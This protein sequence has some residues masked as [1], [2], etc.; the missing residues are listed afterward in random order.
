MQGDSI[1]EPH[2][3]LWNPSGNC[4]AVIHQ[5]AGRVSAVNRPP[6]TGHSPTLK[7]ASSLGVLLLFFWS[8][9]MGATVTCGKQ[10]AAF[11]T[12]R[13]QIG[14]V[15]FEQTYEKNC[16]PHDP[17]WSCV[18]MGYI[19]EVLDRIF[20]MA[21]SCEGGILQNRSGHI[22]PEGYI[23]GWLTELASPKAMQDVRGT[24]AFGTNF[25]AT[26]PESQRD[27]VLE[28]LE[29]DGYPEVR[30]ALLADGFEVSLHAYFDVLRSIYGKR[31]I[32]AWRFI[33]DVARNGTE[34]PELGYCP[35]KK[36]AP[37][38]RVPRML[39]LD[40]DNLL[41]EQ[42]DGTF[43]SE[44]WAYS[45][46]GSFVANYAA[47]ERAYP[48]SYRSAIKYYRTVAAKALPAPDSAVIEFSI[49]FIDPGE[50]YARESL[51]QFAKELGQ[52]STEFIMTLGQIKTL[53]KEDT[54]LLYRLSGLR[55]LVWTVDESPAV[56]SNQ[57]SLLFG[58]AAA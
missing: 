3:R 44:G 9:Q 20:K 21:S 36:P 16:Y 6:T 27:T 56:L 23:A 58:E 32:G 19:D 10:V 48:G 8:K 42:P 43:R 40:R 35:D 41:V 50:T 25:S 7:G 51:A 38:G 4:I 14:Y 37:Q 34:C 2:G 53:K 33:A 30:Q 22:T 29:Q 45:V 24:L 15:L 13:G 11:T 1:S 54:Y 31:A 28:V 39:L 17:R 26:I 46:V 18:G 49:A 52:P 12:P 57:S 47:T 55:S 5:I